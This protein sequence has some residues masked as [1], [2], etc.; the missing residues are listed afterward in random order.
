[1]ELFK[2]AFFIGLCIVFGCEK[3]AENSEP[4]LNTSSEVF[5]KIFYENPVKGEP[6]LYKTVQISGVVHRIEQTETIVMV[7]MNTNTLPMLFGFRNKSRLATIQ[8]G[9]NVTIKGIV[10][11]YADGYVVFSQCQLQY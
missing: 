5:A 10:Q 1:M 8:R 3:K 7:Y 9:S 6:F 4:I 11:G 2:I